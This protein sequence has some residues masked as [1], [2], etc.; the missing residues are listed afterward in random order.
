M[1]IKNSAPKE[2][3]ALILLDHKNTKVLWARR[4]PKLKFLGGFHGFP[5][6]K[7]DNS[8]T[9]TDVRN[10]NPEWSKFIACA[11]REVFEEVGVLLVRNGERLTKGQIV[12]LHDDLVSGRSTF[13][14][15]LKDW[16][17]WID[18][19]DFIYTGF[20]TTPEFSPIRFKTHFFAASCP[21]KQIPY[22]AITELQEIEFVE[23]ESARNQW[24]NSNVLIAPPVLIALRELLAAKDPYENSI[25]VKE[26]AGR[27][28]KRSES[29]SG[30]IDHIE[31]N[32]RLICLPLKTETLPPATHTNCFIVGKK[33]FVVIDAAARL[34]GEQKKLFSIIGQ[35]IENG[36]SCKGIIVSHLHRDHYGAETALKRYLREKHG[37]DVPISSHKPTAE[38]LTGKVEIV[39]FIEDNASYELEDENGE[40]F[41]LEVLH[42][43]GHA[44]GHLCFYDREF[45]FLL[46]SDNVVGLGTV[47]IAPPEGDMNEY[48]DSLE[49]M[50]HLPN[51]NFLCGSHGMAV[52]DA[53]ARIKEYIEHRKQREISILEVVRQGTDAPGEIVD[54]VYEG[55]SPKLLPLAEK[56]VE[57]HLAKLRLDGL[58]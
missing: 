37:L 55:L 24:A 28:K 56:S 20:W 3:A 41:S 44:R 29:V 13:A 38:S 25:N 46:S 12:S 11:V 26:A 16:G 36:N 47:V 40:P 52:Y 53:K 54:I 48:F 19:E 18:A 35:M 21:K 10:S 34:E 51:L 23:P 58:I 45:G 22:P 50:K 8:D 5:G 2:A 30:N 43:P 57:A 17:L 39:T 32:S 6:G 42:T 33:Q 4:N 9:E 1:R 15:I 27:L 7:V 31:L 14:E 49:R